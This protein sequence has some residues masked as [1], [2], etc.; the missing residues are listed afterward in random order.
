MSC[1]NSG[2]FLSVE[3]WF[4]LQFLTTLN[5]ITP[6]HITTNT[7]Q[8]ALLRAGQ[9]QSLNYI[10]IFPFHESDLQLVINDYNP[11]NYSIW[12][13]PFM[14]PTMVELLIYLES[15]HESLNQSLTKKPFTCYIADRDPGRGRKWV[16]I[17]SV[18]VVVVP[19]PCCRDR[20][21][22][23]STVPPTQPA[24]LKC[25]THLSSPDPAQHSL[26]FL[27][28]TPVSALIKT[29]TK[30]VSCNTQLTQLLFLEGR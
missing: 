14:N 8:H 24:P 7:K 22:D 17:V 4:L 30:A 18:L 19:H 13:N 26:Q 23:S 20:L 16:V 5:T 28:S 25:E 21:S 2:N 9:I 12:L 3:C 15:L 6:R 10:D 11:D 29:L 27:S 1:H